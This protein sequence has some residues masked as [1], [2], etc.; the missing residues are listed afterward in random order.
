MHEGVRDVNPLKRNTEV[1]ELG[2]L[3]LFLCSDMGRGITGDVIFCDA[4]YHVMGM[5]P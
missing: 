5:K 1:S 3:A 2:D 4:G